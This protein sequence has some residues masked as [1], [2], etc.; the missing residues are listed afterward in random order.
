MKRG[1]KA[2]L[3]VLGLAVAAA[4]FWVALMIPFE[5]LA[6]PSTATPT[7]EILVDLRSWDAAT[8]P[9]RRAAAEDVARR[10]PDFALLRMETFSCGGQTH[11]VAIYMHAKTGMEFVLVPSGTFVMG[12]AE[13]EAGRYDNEG[14]QHRV[15]IAQPYL[16]ARTECT[17]AA[18]SRLLGASPSAATGADQPVESVSWDDA[19]EF[20]R[21]AGLRLPSEAEWEYACR[22]G[23]TTRYWSGDS[24]DDLTRV[25][26]VGANSD[27]AAR[28][29]GKLLRYVGATPSPQG[30]DPVGKRPANPFGLFDMHGNVSEWCEDRWHERYQSAPT[31]E[32]AWVD[33]APGT[34]VFR[35]GSWFDPVWAA[36]SASR[37][38][39]GQGNRSVLVGF[40]PAKT[41][42][43]E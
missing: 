32:R 11:E 5:H 18:Y 1:A 27:P 12:S 2:A 36:R 10:L 6:P 14:P 3:V 31:D 38:N 20:C 35:G 42:P 41:V 28:V 30:H 26:C 15:Q 7:R 17:Q 25:G 33:N 9:A 8:V 34:R 40:R 22:A 29:P 19:E 21:R 24:E 13:S 4:P 23:T 39:R 43:T 37:N 16:L